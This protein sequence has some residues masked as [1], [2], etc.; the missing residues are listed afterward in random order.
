LNN[1][2]QTAL[3]NNLNSVNVSLANLNAAQE[4]YIT[5][6][7]LAGALQGQQ[8]SN[9][10]Q[11]AIANAARYSEAANLTFTA[12]QQTK[13]HN[14]SLMQSIGLANLDAKQATVLQNASILANM[15]ITNL[16]NRQQT[17]VQNAKTFLDTD[18]TNLNNAQQ[19]ELFRGKANIDA[20]LTDS[21][22]DNAAKQLN[23]TEKNKTDQFFTQLA[24]NISM[25]NTEQK[26]A[27]AQFNAGEEN[28]GTKFNAQMD[29]ARKQFNASNSL[30]IAQAN[31]VWRQN[32]TTLNTA[33][34]N[35]SNRDM[36]ATMNA[37]TSK[38]LDE[39][40]QKERD[41]FA[42][43]FTSTE[44]DKD[45]AVELML[46]DKRDDLVRWQEGKQEEAAK[47]AAI[48]KLIFG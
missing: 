20:L 9:K 4:A 37:L 7:N 40:W 17:A 32:T 33:A 39:V 47:A 24:S 30:A 31:A 23:V 5:N 38:A 25:F 14:S 19:V 36:A 12:D 3:Q 48:V 26:N 46:S 8:I 1:R 41:I 34:K 10:Q 43:A 18:L 35:D 11:A 6:A 16:N 45:R 42:Y 28:A 13:L 29:A 27:I 2:Q 44:S 15:D 22:A 21:A